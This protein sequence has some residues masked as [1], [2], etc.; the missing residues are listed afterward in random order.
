[1]KLA[2]TLGAG[3]IAGFVVVAL[4]VIVAGLLRY[5]GAV[6]AGI[7]RGGLRAIPW[8][9]W[10]GMALFSMVGA[11]AFAIAYALVFELITR[12]AGAMMGAAIGVGH[13]VGVWLGIGLLSWF[14]PGPSQHFDDALFILFNS[15]WAI[16]GFILVHVVYGATVGA[17]YGSP[18]RK[19]AVQMRIA[20]RELDLTA[21]GGE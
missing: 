15:T 6:R 17:V 12:R 11:V 8:V 19:S 5:D 21:K 7:E 10:V 13:G 18:R 2:R 20:S 14:F 1:M 9:G 3:I 4:S 16:A